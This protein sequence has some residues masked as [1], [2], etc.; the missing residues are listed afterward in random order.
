MVNSCAD[1]LTENFLEW[2]K[3]QGQ[4]RKLKDYADFLGIHEVTLNQLING[5]K[6]ASKKMLVTLAE[7]TGDPR[8]YDVANLPRPDPD[9]QTIT[10]LWPYLTE[11]S[12]H[13]ILKQAEKYATDNEQASTQSKP[14]NRPKPAAKPT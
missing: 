13:T 6:D 7:K 5:R 11:D 10:R 1:L 2:Q 8:F 4:V 14:A 3:S 12:R 9:L